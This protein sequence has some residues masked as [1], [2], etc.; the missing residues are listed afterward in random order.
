MDDVASV[1]CW[2]GVHRVNFLVKGAQNRNGD[3][4]CHA[5]EMPGANDK[6]D[7][8]AQLV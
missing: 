6:G 3:I 7:M 8:R 4:R 5:K 2:S 1:A